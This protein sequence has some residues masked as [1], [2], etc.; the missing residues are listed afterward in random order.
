MNE[1]QLTRLK[2]SFPNNMEIVSTRAINSMFTGEH[3][4]TESDIGLI[5][6]NGEEIH[7]P[8]RIYSPETMGFQQLNDIELKILH[9]LYTRHH[10]GYVRAK[11]ISK[12]LPPSDIWVIPFVVQLLG[13]YIIEISEL[14]QSRMTECDKELFIKFKNEN[15][16]FCELTSNRI[17]SYWNEY[18][19]SKYQSIEDYT[20][21]IVANYLG[22]WCISNSQ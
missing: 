17:I 10:N 21:F 14:I 7:I 3:N 2:K 5:K 11:Y 6:I 22:V 8:S 13:E 1:V 18:Y 12:I 4:P 20:P 9:C 15:T 19:R 16:S